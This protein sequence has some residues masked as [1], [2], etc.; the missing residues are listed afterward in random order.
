MRFC[1]VSRDV[2]AGSS[3][4]GSEFDFPIYTVTPPRDDDLVTVTDYGPTAW[5]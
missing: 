2:F 5:F 1:I 3:D 4:Y